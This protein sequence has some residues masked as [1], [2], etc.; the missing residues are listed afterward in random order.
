M[1]RQLE[2]LGFLKPPFTKAKVQ[3]AWRLWEK[4]KARRATIREAPSAMRD[5]LAFERVRSLELGNSI[6]RIR[7]T[8]VSRR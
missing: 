6:R 5:A 3:A 8:S 7:S 4:D 2:G 1:I